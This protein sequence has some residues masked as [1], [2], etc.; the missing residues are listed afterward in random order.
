MVGAIIG[1]D[2]WLQPRTPMIRYI[3]NLIPLLV[4]S[5]CAHSPPPAPSLAPEPEF[6]EPSSVRTLGLEFRKDSL[7]MSIRMSG[8]ELR[9]R[10]AIESDGS[11]LYGSRTILAADPGEYERYSLVER[12]SV[13]CS[14][15]KSEVPRF[16]EGQL[17]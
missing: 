5:A 7:G 6:H 16:E 17:V 4:V 11:G 12:I 9:Y 10:V 2:G 13:F 8:K 15:P 3:L 14:R 1:V